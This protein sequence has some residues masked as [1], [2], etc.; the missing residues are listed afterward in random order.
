M[1]LIADVRQ[2]ARRRQSVKLADEANAR[3]EKW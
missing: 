2:V 3:M 1:Q